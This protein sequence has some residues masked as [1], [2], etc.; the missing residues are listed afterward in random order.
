MG[1]NL[2]FC[3]Y[4]DTISRL[5]RIENDAK[6][7]LA[8]AL[9]LALVSRLSLGIIFFFLFD[10]TKMAVDVWI[11]IQYSIQGPPTQK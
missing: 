2:F 6:D 10:E 11:R 3:R 8:L 7:S 1:R 4:C 9:A 5:G